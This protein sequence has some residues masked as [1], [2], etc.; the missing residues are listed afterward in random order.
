MNIESEHC[1]EA[2]LQRLFEIEV[3]LPVRSRTLEQEQC[4]DYFLANYR[5][6]ENGRHEVGIPL[7][8]DF[9]QLGSSCSIALHRYRQLE[10]RFVRDPELKQKYQEA[11]SERINEGHMKLVSRLPSC[12]CFHIPHHAVTS[13]GWYSTLHALRTEIY[14]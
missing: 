7:R 6:T 2:L 14:P 12:P 1:M 5:R 10:R 3:L 11:M 4:E 8:S 13:F 9:E